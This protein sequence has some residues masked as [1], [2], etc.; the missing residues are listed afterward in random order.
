[1]PA[2]DCPSVPP[3]SPGMPSRASGSPRYHGLM[4][5]AVIP[6]AYGDPAPLAPASVRLNFRLNDAVLALDVADH[7]ALRLV[8]DAY[9]P[10]LC[11]PAG[12][13]ARA[14][15]KRL[16]DGQLH[17][18]YGQH[19]LRLA[20]GADRLA[21]RAAYHAAREIFAR[22]A[23]EPRNCVAVYGALCAIDGEAILLLGPTAIGKTLLALHLA[24]AGAQ[25]L[26]DETVVLHPGAG[27]ACAMPRRPSLRESALPLL[28][29]AEMGERIAASST[30]FETERG[31]FWYALDRDALGGIEPC[32]RRHRLRAI[33]VVRE[34]AEDYAIRRIERDQTVKSIAHRA[35]Q[36]PSS[37]AQLAALTRATRS[38]ACFE[39]TLG[40]PRESA[41]A[42]LRE[43]R[44]CE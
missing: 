37:L 15:L 13:H 8:E 27:E 9:A 38:A 21:V 32:A 44:A 2:A 16:T 31:R 36:R 19:S 10:L 7:A 40:A 42:L 17:V 6:S 25:F 39:M 33:V 1:M 35:Y 5:T 11:P 34:R 14:S 26:G 43:V 24:A 23:C 3:R 41:Q 20:N 4:A 22:F 18:R 29:A 12:A 28:P 30:F